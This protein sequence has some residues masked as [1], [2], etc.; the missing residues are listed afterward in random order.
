MVKDPSATGLKE[1]INAG[2]SELP[3]KWEMVMLC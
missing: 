2:N 3:L 1:K